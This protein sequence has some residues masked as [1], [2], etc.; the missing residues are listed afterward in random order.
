MAIIE[1]TKFKW[2]LR[3]KKQLDFGDGIITDLQEEFKI[4]NGRIDFLGINKDLKKFYLI[5]VKMGKIN[6]PALEQTL[7]Y[8]WNFEKSLKYSPEYKDYDVQCYIMGKSCGPCCTMRHLFPKVKFVNR[9]TLK[10]EKSHGFIEWDSDK[11]QMIIDGVNLW[12]Y[13]A[14]KQ[15]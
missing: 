3:K 9:K 5:E 10:V 15:N 4:M 13:F 6:L 7:N 11:E 8:L 2:E 12:R 1:E 14:K